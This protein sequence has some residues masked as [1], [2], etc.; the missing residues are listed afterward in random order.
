MNF[1]LLDVCFLHLN[2]RKPVLVLEVDEVDSWPGKQGNAGPAS[3]VFV[4][5][6]ER[7]LSLSSGASWERLPGCKSNRLTTFCHSAVTQKAASRNRRHTPQ[8]SCVQS[9]YG[10][11]GGGSQLLPHCLA[12][13]QDCR[14]PIPSPPAILLLPSI[15]FIFGPCGAISQ[16]DIVL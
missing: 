8:L 7:S 13:L 6:S 15:L 10:N 9:D 1:V 5:Q 16:S 2:I 4:P 12:L 3:R 14:P 11:S